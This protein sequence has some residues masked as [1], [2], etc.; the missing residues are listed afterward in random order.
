MKKFRVT[1]LIE[2]A[3]GSFDGKFYCRQAKSRGDALLDVLATEAG[4][5]MNL[6]Q[7][8]KSRVTEVPSTPTL[9]GLNA[10]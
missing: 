7:V 3:P 10:I 6:N 2:N 1:L 4:Q 9:T 8:R 5:G